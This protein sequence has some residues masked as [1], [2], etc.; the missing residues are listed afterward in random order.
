MISALTWPN[1]LVLP[2]RMYKNTEKKQAMLA[3]L[4]SGT[5][6]VPCSRVRKRLCY[7]FSLVLIVRPTAVEVG[8]AAS[9]SEVG[10]LH[11]R[12]VSAEV[13]SM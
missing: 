8:L 9:V 5:Q 10:A 1:K 3:V 4:K 11:L 6:K 13:Y 2:P 12:I 7:N